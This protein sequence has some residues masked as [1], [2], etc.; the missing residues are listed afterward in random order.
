ML[1][2]PWGFFY[3]VPQD[4]QICLPPCCL[5]PHSLQSPWPGW[6]IASSRD[7][8]TQAQP[9]WAHPGQD[10]GEHS[11]A[12]RHWLK[13]GPGAVCGVRIPPEHPQSIPGA[14][15]P[16]MVHPRMG[17]QELPHTGRSCAMQLAASEWLVGLGAGWAEDAQSSCHDNAPLACGDS[18]DTSFSPKSWKHLSGPTTCTPPCTPGMSPHSSPAAKIKYSICIAGKS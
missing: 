4:T 12:A 3:P 18:P 17:L 8:L 1:G 11:E 7:I 9:G 6:Q 15:S 16:H 14:G 5:Q 10:R 13:A 2:S